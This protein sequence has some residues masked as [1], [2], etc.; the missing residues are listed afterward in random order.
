MSCDM[1]MAIPGVTNVANNGPRVPGYLEDL[2]PCQHR[3]LRWALV[4]V[5]QHA[6]ALTVGITEHQQSMRNAG[7]RV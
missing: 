7:S 2:E 5:Q 3:L 1:H 4:V 6:V